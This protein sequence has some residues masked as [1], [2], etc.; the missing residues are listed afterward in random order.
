[1]YDFTLD[2]TEKNGPLSVTPTGLLDTQAG[3]TAKPKVG[4]N[5]EIGHPISQLVVFNSNLLI[6]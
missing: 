6:S 2:H 3:H 1:M 4:D 5:L